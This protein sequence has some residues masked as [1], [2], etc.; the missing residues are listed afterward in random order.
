MGALIETANASI[1]VQNLPVVFGM[2]AEMKLL[3]HNLV[4]NAI[5]FKKPD[6]RPIIRISA[7]QKESEFIF[8]IEDN[9]V[10]IDERA[11]VKIFMLFR[12]M[13]K[14]DEYEGIGIG[15]AHCKKIVEMHGGKIWVEGE[16]GRGSTFRFT[17]PVQN[18]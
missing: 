12:Q 14:R 6:V 4:S 18:Q 10:G 3:F 17:L 8:A 1:V 13:R 9:G 2:E 11:K 7:E 5:K 16:V 15:L